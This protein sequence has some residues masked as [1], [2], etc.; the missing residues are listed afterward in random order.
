M[1]FFLDSLSL[2]SSVEFF[3]VQVVSL[4]SLL[5]SRGYS[6]GFLLKANQG[7]LHDSGVL[8]R[9]STFGIFQ[10]EYLNG[11]WFQSEELFNAYSISKRLSTEGFPEWSANNQIKRIP[12][13][14]GQFP[15]FKWE[16][17][18][19]VSSIHGKRWMISAAYLAEM[20]H[21]YYQ[22]KTLESFSVHSWLD[23]ELQVQWLQRHITYD[24]QKS[25]WE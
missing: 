24:N 4:I 3:I 23:Q 21:A 20:K 2:W 8:F 11:F 25:F 13:N 9:I 15:E 10:N 12:T 22:Y 5:K 1:S 7:L 6:A 18:T 17:A 19:I 16:A 14:A